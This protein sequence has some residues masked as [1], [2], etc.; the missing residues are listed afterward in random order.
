MPGSPVARIDKSS[1]C[2]NGLAALRPGLFLFFA[3]G[4][5]GIKT[6]FFHAPIKRSPAES[7]DF[8]RLGYVTAIASQRFTDEQSFH[9]FKA[10]IGKVNGPESGRRL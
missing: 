8:R 9:F 4:G 6:V 1:R 5:G 7:Q 2:S 3:K 10:H